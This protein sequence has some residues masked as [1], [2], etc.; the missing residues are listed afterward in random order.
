MT[1]DFFKMMSV[2]AGI[3]ALC[4][5]FVFTLGLMKAEREGGESITAGKNKKPASLFFSVERLEKDLEETVF[6]E[7]FP[8][9]PPRLE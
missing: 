2:F 3:I 4:L 1:A 6:Y 5:I 7:R 9:H 8:E